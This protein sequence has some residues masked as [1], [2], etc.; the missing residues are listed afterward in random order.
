MASSS[1]T[2]SVFSS[3][4]CISVRV[5]SSCSCLCEIKRTMRKELRVYCKRGK[6]EPISSS[7]CA[8]LL[9]AR[10]GEE[11][12]KPQ[13]RLIRS[14]FGTRRDATGADEKPYKITN[15]NLVLLKKGHFLHT[16]Y[17]SQVILYISNHPVVVYSNSRHG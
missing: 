2:M 16:A 9:R 6:K 4:T 10:G 12:Q 7:I 5:S 13:L 1:S 17:G 8:L 15:N 14:P 3:V 11:G